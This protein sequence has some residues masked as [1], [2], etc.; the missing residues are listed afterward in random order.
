VRRKIDLEQVILETEVV[1]DEPVRDARLLGD[2]ENAA[3][4]VAGPREDRDR[5][6]QDQPP[7]L[8]SSPALVA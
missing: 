4:V 3:R 1:V 2:V 5:R 7:F 8:L 6:A